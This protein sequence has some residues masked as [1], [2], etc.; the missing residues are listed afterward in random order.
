MTSP[1]LLSY[2]LNQRGTGR[3][4]Q[5]MEI[6]YPGLQYLSVPVHATHNN[7]FHQG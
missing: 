4:F 2:K 1:G 6:A 3:Y 7:E 5:G